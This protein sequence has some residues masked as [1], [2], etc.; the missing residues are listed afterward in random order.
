M[1]GGNLQGEN[2]KDFKNYIIGFLTATCMF[3]FMGNTQNKSDGHFD[4]IYADQIICKSMLV[5]N[6][7]DE[8]KVYIE[9]NVV[10]II[11][12]ENEYLMQTYNKLL[13][14]NKGENTQIDLHNLGKSLFS[15]I[16]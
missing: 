14:S 12:S 10:K 8:K 9:P 2:M 5:E 4:K 3:L 1:S 16:F 6:G 11:E 15:I 13:I 7:V